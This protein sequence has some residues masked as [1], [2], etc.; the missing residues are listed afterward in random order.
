VQQAKEP[1]QFGG[2]GG[3]DRGDALSAG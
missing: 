3:R 2:G 1:G